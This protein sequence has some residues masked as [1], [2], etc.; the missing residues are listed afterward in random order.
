[1]PM[2]LLTTVYR[3][4]DDAYYLAADG[5]FIDQY[6]DRAQADHGAACIRALNLAG[7][8]VA[9]ENPRKEPGCQYGRIFVQATIGPKAPNPYNPAVLPAH[10]T[11][12]LEG[13]ASAARDVMGRTL[14]HMS[15]PYALIAEL[16][17]LD[18]AA[19][20]YGRG[21]YDSIEQ[22]QELI[23]VAQGDDPHR[24]A[25]GHDQPRYVHP[26]NLQ[27]WIGRIAD[28]CKDDGADPGFIPLIGGAHRA[29]WE[30]MYLWYRAQKRRDARYAPLVRSL[31]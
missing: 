26:D 23:K 12:E 31:Y 6:R 24:Y 13:L 17:Q 20:D 14:D 19:L 30:A 28:A 16:R 1:M 8:S 18:P 29:V 2:Q 7:Y 22:Y 11:E 4:G 10:Y 25:T 27:S 21:R 9:G 15:M 3:Y 5:G